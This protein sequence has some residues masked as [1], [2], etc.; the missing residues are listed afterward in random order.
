MHRQFLMNL[1][2]ASIWVALTGELL[3]QNLVFGFI[4]GFFLLWLM[5]RNED[6]RRYFYQTPTD[7]QFYHV[8]FL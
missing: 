2:L 8:F 3:F 1:M 7:H 5:N 6:D 4:L